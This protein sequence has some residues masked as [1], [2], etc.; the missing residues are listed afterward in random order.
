MVEGGGLKAGPGS[1]AI[2]GSEGAHDH[3][4]RATLADPQGGGRVSALQSPRPNLLAS[5]VARVQ[6]A[7]WPRWGALETLSRVVG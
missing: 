4:P 3:K 5:W 2:A 1:L 7:P 6:T